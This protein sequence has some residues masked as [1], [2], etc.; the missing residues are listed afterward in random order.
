M[1]GIYW[2]FWRGTHLSRPRTSISSEWLKAA[3]R[4]F[5]LL[6]DVPKGGMLRQAR[7]ECWLCER[8]GTLV[9]GVPDSESTVVLDLCC[10]DLVA[11]NR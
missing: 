8:Q 2:V 1:R 11:L 5:M 4:I 10:V 3:S 9:Q 6:C 7:F